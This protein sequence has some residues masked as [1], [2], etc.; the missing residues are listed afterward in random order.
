MH[1]AL[2]WRFQLCVVFSPLPT[3]LDFNLFSVGHVVYC[4]GSLQI[5]NCGSLVCHTLRLVVE[6]SSHH[7]KAVL[8]T[9]TVSGLYAVMF[10]V[11]N[12]CLCCHFLRDQCTRRSLADSCNFTY[13]FTNRFILPAVI[14]QC[15]SAIAVTVVIK[16]YTFLYWC[17]CE[18]EDIQWWLLLKQR[19]ISLKQKP[20]HVAGAHSYPFSFCYEHAFVTDCHCGWR[21]NGPQIVGIY[22]CIYVCQFIVFLVCLV[23]SVI[24]CWEKKRFTLIESLSWVVRITWH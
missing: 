21:V 1:D 14:C 24:V 6:A 5:V 2:F 20:M 17:K 19:N 9:D 3:N 8:S 18:Q 7:Y 4:F 10:K 16:V 22:S 12:L 11:F 13:T 23:A 15:T